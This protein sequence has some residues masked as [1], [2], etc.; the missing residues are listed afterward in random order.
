MRFFQNYFYSSTLLTLTWLTIAQGECCLNILLTNDD[1]Y[2]TLL[3]T[4]LF[5][6][7]R[8]ET[9]HNVKLVAPKG[10]QSGMGSAIELFQ[11]GFDEGNPETDVFFID[12]T[13][14]TTTLYGLDI[15]CAEANFKPDL[16][17]SG[18][19][20]GWNQGW[21]AQISGTVNGAI[22]GMT[23]DYP[24]I[25]VS[26]SQL[27]AESEDS[28]ILIAKI[29]TN[30]IE[31]KLYNRGKLILGKG[32]GVTVNIPTVTGADADVDDYTF[33][34][35]KIGRG[36]PVGGAKFYRDLKDSNIAEIYFRG[37]F[38]G[39]SGLGFSYPYNSAGLPLDNDPDS[40]YNVL[41]DQLTG[42]N[43]FVVT[44]SPMQYSFTVEPSTNIQ[45][46]FTMEEGSKLRKVSNND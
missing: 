23:R 4:T 30:L 19:N 34:L 27:D 32:E 45:A 29:I 44:V 12:S 8:N 46:A 16:V 3:T 37:A 42:N 38:R 43:T 35:T 18:P 2:D 21:A 36:N 26:A 28:A 14:V 41:G 20:E 10:A 17:L 6:H 5:K 24:A 1:G 39:Q 9:C 15:V 22:A 13:P 33:K 40:E 7:L 25:S 11:T 31:M